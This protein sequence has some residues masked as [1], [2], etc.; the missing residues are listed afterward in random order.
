MAAA[1]NASVRWI[2]SYVLG[3]TR[4]LIEVDEEKRGPSGREGISVST[5]FADIASSLQ[6]LN[7]GGGE[8]GGRAYS[9][10]HVETSSGSSKPTPETPADNS[11]DSTHDWLANLEY[12]APLTDNELVSEIDPGVSML[13]YSMFD[14]PELGNLSAW[15]SNTNT[16]KR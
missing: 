6:P 12:L 3:M 9:D 13:N 8:S 14:N 4:R 11:Y 5:A 15:F 2:T 1:S 7:S 16:A 10:S